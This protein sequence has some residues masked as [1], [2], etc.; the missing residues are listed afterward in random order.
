MKSII[1]GDFTV[2]TTKDGLTISQEGQ[3]KLTAT[4][5]EVDKITRLI[6]IGLGMETMKGLPSHIKHSPFV[7]RFFE[8]NTMRLERTDQEGSLRFSFREGDE[9]IKVFQSGL[10]I[11]I[12]EKRLEDLPRGAIGGGMGDFIA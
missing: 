9:I 6:G 8:D 5:A 12:D 2:G 1:I 11:A 7:L 3:P 4:P 10:A